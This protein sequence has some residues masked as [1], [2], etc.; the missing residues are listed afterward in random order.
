MEAV[1][2][3][4]IG[5][6]YTKVTAVDI[7]S[8]CVVGTAKSFTTIETDVNEGLEKAIGELNL[9]TGITEFSGKFACSSAAGGLK[10]IAVGLVPG[11]TAE[12]AKMAAL[13]AG[14]KVMKTYSYKLSTKEAKEIYDLKPDIVLLSGGT[15]GG[16]SSVILHNARVIAGICWNFPVVVAG[17]KSAVDD[18]AAILSKTSKEVRLCE[19]VMP[20]F[21]VLNI[22]PARMLI[23]EIFLERIIR[24][25]GLTKVQELVEGILMPTPSAV[26]NAAHYLSVGFEDEKGV[27][28]L[29]VVDVGGATTDVYSINDGSPNMAGVILKG[30]PEPFEKR[31]VEGDLGVRYNA[32]TLLDTAGVGNIAVRSGLTR[33]EVV[34]STGLVN[35]NP[36]ILPSDNEKISLLDNGLAAMA[37]RLATERHAGSIDTE[38]TPCG[39]VY[40]Q[41]GKD[42]GRVG[43]IIGTGGPVINCSNP[44]NILKEAMFDE[45]NPGVLKPKK[46]EFYIDKK[47]ILAAM[48]LLCVKYP[49]IAVRIMKK[50]LEMISWS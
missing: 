13:S 48:G 6:T 20:E 3:I 47:Y 4:D 32:A 46:A 10:M 30:L 39:S 24:A 26:L 22:E 17:N 36:G 49:E 12:A 29:M 15:N 25:K 23:R 7:K 1:L 2:L 31:T 11:L 19:N 5:S 27:G 8:E 44:E 42:M 34:Y 9:K 33:E 45:A 40:V 37:V 43:R 28:D 41:T 21:N 50:E 38:Y 18:V 16:N 35:E 14:A